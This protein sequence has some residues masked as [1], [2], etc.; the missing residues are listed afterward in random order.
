[1]KKNDYVVKNI[2]VSAS[3]N[4]KSDV[5]KNGFIKQ[6]FSSIFKINYAGVRQFDSKENFNN[7]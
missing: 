4:L 6:I 5:Y 7:E 1:M 3:L 2:S